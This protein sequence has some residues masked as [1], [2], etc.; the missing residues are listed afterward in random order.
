MPTACRRISA[1]IV[2]LLMMIGPAQALAATPGQRCEAAKLK[3]AGVKAKKELACFKTAVATGK[4]VNGDCLARAE[5]AF[6]RA[7]ERAEGKGGC[8]TTG[9][10]A[11]VEA[12]VD[13]AVA[14]VNAI[15]GVTPLT[16]PSQCTALKLAATGAKAVRKL[17]C[18][19]EAVM[20]G[21]FVKASCL[22][23]AEGSFSKAFTKAE[24]KSDCL[25]TGDAG[26]VESRVD[27]LV[28]DG[29]TALVPP[30]RV[31]V[32]STSSTGN[33]GGL[34]G[35]DA[36]C[37]S[38][39]ASAGLTGTYKAWL[40]D[41]RKSAADRL[42]QSIS[43]YVLVN[44][45][46]IA[47]DWGDLTNGD[48]ENLIDLDE[49]GAVVPNNEVWTGTFSDGFGFGGCNDWTSADPNAP[50]PNV[51]TTSQTDFGWTDV[52]LQFCDRTNVRLYCFEQ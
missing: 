29:R 33:L 47:A 18:Y 23:R 1:L 28:A 37:A 49:T 38:L 40:S 10:A 31:F 20:A 44:A 51:G 21:K 24:G 34:A 35:A 45:T 13:S 48:I 8:V 19:A 36:T 5:A 42:T 3:A 4:V 30:K 2:A 27:T 22:A 15:L 52:F 7:F 39:A 11:S 6:A 14:D 26:T 43:P 50:F 16:T 32:S 9:D 41:S 46:E 17:T 25:T 12:T